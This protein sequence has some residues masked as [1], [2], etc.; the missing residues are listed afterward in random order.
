MVRGRP[1]GSEKMGRPR[2][3]ESKR[4]W[5]EESGLTVVL[6]GGLELFSWLGGEVSYV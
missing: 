3:G 4:Q 2:Q 5:M 6:I 1:L